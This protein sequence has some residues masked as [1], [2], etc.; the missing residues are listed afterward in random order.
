MELVAYFRSFEFGYMLCGNDGAVV[1]NGGEL[2]LCCALGNV[3]VS[4][5]DCF[6]LESMA[7][8]LLRVNDL[9]DCS[10]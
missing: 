2:Y 9:V 8:V 10:F 3:V 7:L 5:A 1:D 6:R 4:L